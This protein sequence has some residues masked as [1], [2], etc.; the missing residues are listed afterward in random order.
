MPR[1]SMPYSV[2][3][4][5]DPASLGE[6]CELGMYQLPETFDTVA[7]AKDAA[8][9][10]IAGLNCEPTAVIYTVQNS[11]GVTVVVNGEPAADN[12]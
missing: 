10:H 9:A 11:E 6:D 7:D 5:A 8:T 4:T 2:E 12:L 3:I 1:F